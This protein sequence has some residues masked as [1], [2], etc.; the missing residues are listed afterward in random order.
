MGARHLRDPVR[1][2]PAGLYRSRSLSAII[3]QL[4][5]PIKGFGLTNGKIGMLSTC[6]L[7]SY[8]LVN[9]AMGSAGD[10]FRRT[11]LIAAGVA[12]WSLATVATAYAQS[13]TQL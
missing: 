13:Y 8:S 11:W 2:A 6:F 3:P 12:V 1:D 10:R 4:K 5:D 7:I 9:P